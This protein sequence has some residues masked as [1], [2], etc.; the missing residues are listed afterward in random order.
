MAIDTMRKKK[1]D[2]S[3]RK[4]WFSAL[5]VEDYDFGYFDNGHKHQIENRND[6]VVA[7]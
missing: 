6:A 5:T 7:D 3:K 1:E 4:T 2:S